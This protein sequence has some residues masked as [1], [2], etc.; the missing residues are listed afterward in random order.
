M[1]ILTHC[2]QDVRPERPD[3]VHQFRRHQ[4]VTGMA[5]PEAVR[6]HQVAETRTEFAVLVSVKCPGRG[7]RDGAVGEPLSGDDRLQPLQTV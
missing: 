1:Q 5:D 7:D 4:G 6:F 3:R 2:H